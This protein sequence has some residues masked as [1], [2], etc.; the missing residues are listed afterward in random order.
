[1]SAAEN[2]AQYGRYDEQRD[3]R[4]DRPL[5]GLFADLARETANLARSEIAL[6]KAELTDK[7]TE[8]AGGVAFIAIGGLV[9]F[10]GFLVL[11]AAAVLG[12]SNVISPWLSALIVG[13][14]V[15]AVGGILAYV[16]KNRLKPDNLRPRRTM[17]TLDEDKRWARSQLA[18]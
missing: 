14:V 3:P 18:R 11:L 12:L 10:A 1:M 15:L 7:A 5:A 8:A 13:V 17:H 9:A 6:A 16:G 4:Q 2:R